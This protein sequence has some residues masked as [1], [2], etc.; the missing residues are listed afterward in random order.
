[1]NRIIDIL[2]TE[3]SDAMELFAG[4]ATLSLGVWGLI[5]PDPQP[6][7]PFAFFVQQNAQVWWSVFLI[8]TGASVILSLVTGDHASRSRSM[9]LSSLV[10]LLKFVVHAMSGWQVWS[11]PLVGQM[12]TICIICLVK[13]STR[14]T[15]R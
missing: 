14:P 12:A 7:N 11:L 1:M 10:W 2:L 15:D 6:G 3:R 13:L 5:L 9:V 4:F 8:L